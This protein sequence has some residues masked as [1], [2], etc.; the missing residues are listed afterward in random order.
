MAPRIAVQEEKAMAK[1]FN[2]MVAE[3]R[4][5]VPMISPADA[6]Q[7]LDQDPNALIIDV[8][9][10]DARAGTGVIPGAANIS[11]GTLPLKADQEL[12]ENL[13]DA[14]LQD[15]S[16]P[17]IVACGRGGQASLGAKLLKDMGFTDVHIL[18]GGTQ[19]WKDAGLPTEPPQG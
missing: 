13:R 2:Q 8:R 11:L 18:E 14:R 15:R 6:K 17:I 7:R 3:A 4:A 19:G 10:A 1:S 5:E 9:D 16:R 12:P